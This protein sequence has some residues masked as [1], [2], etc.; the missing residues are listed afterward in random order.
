MTP[1]LFQIKSIQ[2][3]NDFPAELNVL[4]EEKWEAFIQ[5]CET[6]SYASLQNHEVVDILK[7]LFILLKST[8]F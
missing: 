3:E 2:Y 7:K 5:A 8:N 1:D 4:A 6:R